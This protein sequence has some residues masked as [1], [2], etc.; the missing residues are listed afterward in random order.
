[1]QLGMVGL[2]RMGS[3]M[4]ERLMRGGHSCVAYDRS[5]Q[6]V[7]QSAGK[8]ATGAASL[9]ELV[10]KLTP[11]RAVWVMVPAGAPTEGTVADL[12]KLLQAGDAIL[13]G[14]NTYVKDDVRRARTLGVR[15][16]YYPDGG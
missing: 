10:K 4:V 8:G 9:E 16:L 2:G 1:M 7:Q 13:D 14:G 3:N 5:A 15:K 11:P 6:A 12:G